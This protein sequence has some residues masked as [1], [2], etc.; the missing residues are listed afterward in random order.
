[1]QYINSYRPIESTKPPKKKRHILRYANLFVFL[2]ILSLVSYNRL[3]LKSYVKALDSNFISSKNNSSAKDPVATAQFNNEINTIIKNNSSVDFGISVKDLSTG[4]QLNYGDTSSMTSA[5]VSKILTATDFLDQV[6]QGNESLGETLE[7]GN[8]ASY[9]LQQMITVSDDN[10]WE[11]LNDDLGYSQIQSYA[12]NQLGL[13]SYDADQ[14][15]LSSSDTANL[16]AQLYQGKLLNQSD[17]QLLLS[18]METAN[19]RTFIIPAVPSSDTVYHKVGE[20]GNEINDAAIITNGKQTI[21]LSI[22][23]NSDNSVSN[24]QIANLMQEITKDSLSYY[25]LN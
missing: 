7:D 17:T 18:Y 16:L 1:M 19:Y 10:A 22:Y 9:D 25:Q 23:T 12:N 20:Y 2:V 8:T 13:S 5:S 24:D 4:S 11:S 21:V 15:T 14:N 6:E 3:G